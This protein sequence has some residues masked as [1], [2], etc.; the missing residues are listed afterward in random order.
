MLPPYRPAYGGRRNSN[1]APPG[2]RP[3]RYTCPRPDPDVGNFHTC[4]FANGPVKILAVYP[5][6]SRPLIGAELSAC[7]SGGFPV[8]M[9][10][11]LNAKHVDRNSGLITTRGRRLRDYANEHFCLITGRTH[12]PLFHLTPPLPPMSYISY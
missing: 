6:P 4:N 12:P 11:D 2:H 3:L 5:S 8:L 10:G 7:L 1:T 9:A